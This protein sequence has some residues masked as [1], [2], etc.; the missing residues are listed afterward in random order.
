M[1]SN[2]FK[3][4]AFLHFYLCG[5]V[6][7]YTGYQDGQAAFTTLITSSVLLTTCVLSALWIREWRAGDPS[8]FRAFGP[9]AARAAVVVGWA[10][11]VISM[12]A[13][14]YTIV[15]AAYIALLVLLVYRAR[16]MEA[17]ESGY[18]ETLRAEA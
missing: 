13:R 7:V 11:L 4:L 14:S 2:G 8:E 15:Y 9:G 16:T 17:E 10:S 5:V 3:A 1:D 12:A 6:A 18:D